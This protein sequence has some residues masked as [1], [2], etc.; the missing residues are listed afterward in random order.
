MTCEEGGFY[1]GSSPYRRLTTLQFQNSVNDLLHV[2][3]P[4]GLFPETSRSEDFRTWN[5][6]NV[7]SAGGAEGIMLA[8]EYI[9]QHVDL[10]LLLDCSDTESESECGERILNELAVRA[11]RRPLTIKESDIITSFLDSGLDTRS[12]VQMGIEI[13][14]SLPQFLYIDA[15]GAGPISESS[16]VEHMDQY[17]I[18]SRLSYFS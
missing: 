3:V 7:V 4:D 12:A 9:A 16:D 15:S 8:A 1:P 6:N 11:Y 17:A 13:I 14:F 2:V 18:A 10:D 5:S